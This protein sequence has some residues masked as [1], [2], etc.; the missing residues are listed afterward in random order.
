MADKNYKI[1]LQKLVSLPMKAAD[2]GWIIE[3]TAT[4]K[5]PLQGQR[6]YRHGWQSWSFSGWLTLGDNSP[7]P[8]RDPF[9]ILLNED[10]PYADR[11]ARTAAGLTMI[12]EAE[13]KLLLFGALEMGGRIFLEEDHILGKYEQGQGDWLIATGPADTLF[14]SYAQALKERY[15]QFRHTKAPRVWCSWY[16]LYY[17]IS[18]ALLLKVLRG[19]NDL[20]FDVFQIDDGWQQTVG[21]WQPNRKF[22]NGMAEMARQIRKTGRLPGLW[23]APFLIHERSSLF[24]EHPDWLLRDEQGRLVLATKHWGGNVYALDTTHPAVQDWL[25]ALMRQIREWGYEYIKLDFLYAAALPAK[26][27]QEMPREAAYRLGLEILRQ[28]LGDAFLLACG[29]P[30]LPSLGL[31]D[32]IRISPDVTAYWVNRPY[33]QVSG[34]SA[35]GMKNAIYTSLHRLWLQPL[36]HPD[37]DVVYFR[38]RAL[39]LSEAQKSL[40]RDLAWICGY[41][42]TSDLPWWLTSAEREALRTFW[43]HQPKVQK[44]APYRFSLDEREVDFR[45]VLEP[46]RPSHYPKVFAGQLGFLQ[47]AWQLGKPALLASRFGK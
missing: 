7:N 1:D 28:N 30:I 46:I 47:D 4:V 8:P 33:Q 27:Y 15:G 19:L 36:V 25:G 31:C 26:R 10:I 20:P 14:T 37:P 41:R 32:A 5:I 38:H 24:R 2:E 39:H 12:E 43:E 45:P 17:F 22:P 44:V 40:Q 3:R 42:A 11:L 34:W 6:F 18:E 35:P 21:D 9:A 29:A 16:S 13:G 23:L